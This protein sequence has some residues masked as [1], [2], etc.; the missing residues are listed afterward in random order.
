M[1]FPMRSE[2]GRPHY[3]YRSARPLPIAT[4][5]RRMTTWILDVVF[6]YLVAFFGGIQLA[7]LGLQELVQGV[8]DIILGYIIALLFYIPQELSG[9]QTLGKMITKTK[10]VSEDGQPMSF[11]QVVGRSFCRLIPFDAFSYL[12]GDGQPRGWHDRFSK[13]V[14]VSVR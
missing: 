11:G 8:P 6:I 13:T 5:G 3:P 2:S 14:V 10:A 4:R 7:M 1:G 12:G 9:G